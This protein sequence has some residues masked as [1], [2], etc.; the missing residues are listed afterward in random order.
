MIYSF[1]EL[2]LMATGGFIGI[3]IKEMT[4]S[5]KI[6]LRGEILGIEECQTNIAS[7]KLY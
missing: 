7:R 5:F 3:T 4:K 6:E 2:R 1:I